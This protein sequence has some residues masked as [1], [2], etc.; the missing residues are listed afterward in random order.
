MGYLKGL[1]EYLDEFYDKSIFDQVLASK[2]PWEFHLHG[3]RVIRAEVLENLTYDLKVA[4][5]EHGQEEIPKIQVKLLYPADLADSIRPLIK[6]DENTKSLAMEPILSPHRRY[7][8]KNKSLF[9]LM[10]GR[11]VLFFTLLDGEI[12]KGIIAGFSRY[13]IT[14]NLKGGIPVTLL[15]HSIYD[16]K[17]KNGRCFLKSF[18]EKHRDW[19]KSELYAS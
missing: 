11:Q 15:R 14:I 18:Q 17:D 16:L 6:V 5:E 10:K 1:K 4:V 3:H 12:I 19:E 9:P 13:D 8:V 2:K 7:F